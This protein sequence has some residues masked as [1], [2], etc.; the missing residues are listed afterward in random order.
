MIL[1]DCQSLKKQQKCSCEY[2]NWKIR[3][4]W[5]NEHRAEERKIQ[6][7]RTSAAKLKIAQ[8]AYRYK[9][10]LFQTDRYRISGMYTR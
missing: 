7:E 4:N 5:S 3:E 6:K 9:F 2:P 8:T 1:Y 10:V